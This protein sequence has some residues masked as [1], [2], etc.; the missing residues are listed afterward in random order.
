MKTRLAIACTLALVSYIGCTCAVIVDENSF[1]V[2]SFVL[3]AV[4]AA[5]AGLLFDR[6]LN[7]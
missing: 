3:H 5:W 2:Y 1:F 4:G 6:Y 7:K